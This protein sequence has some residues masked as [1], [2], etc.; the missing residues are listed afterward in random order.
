MLR[1]IMEH[2]W[3]RQQMETFSALLAI[4][5]GN[6]PVPGEFPTQRPVTRSFDV[7]FD[8]RPNKRLS[9]QWWGWWFETQSCSLWRHRN[10]FPCVLKGVWYRYCIS[11][12][13]WRCVFSADPFY[14]LRWWEYLT[15]NNNPHLIMIHWPLLRCRMFYHVHMAKNVL[16][17][18]SWCL[19]TYACLTTIIHLCKSQDNTKQTN[20]RTITHMII[21]VC[22]HF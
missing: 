12:N 19:I 6:S 5:V 4:C 1:C 13:I 10:D 22:S 16:C 2:T 8:L 14:S 9:K 15:S 11:C 7:Y 20:R 3:W 18:V 17:L 21:R